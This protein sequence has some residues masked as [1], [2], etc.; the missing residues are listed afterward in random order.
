MKQPNSILSPSAARYLALVV[1]LQFA[2][3]L[4]LW[5]TGMSV[6]VAKA[7]G[8]PDAGAQRDQIIEQ[9]K[10]TNEKLDRLFAL[11]SGGE[12]QVRLSKSDETSKR[13]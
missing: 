4:T 12:L 6:P 3:L 11:L 5:G 10:A 7:D 9:L 8:I 13:Q 1:F 2:V